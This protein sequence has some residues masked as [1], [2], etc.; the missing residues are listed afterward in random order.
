MARQRFISTQTTMIA[1][2]AGWLSAAPALAQQSDDEGGLQANVG[3]H[4]DLNDNIYDSSTQEIES[5]IARISP[6]LLLSSTP[7]KRQFSAQYVGDY[8]K[9][10][11]S[12]DDDYEDHSLT[13]RGLFRRGSRGVL[14][15]SAVFHQSA[16][17]EE[18]LL[19]DCYAPVGREGLIGCTGRLWS[20]SGHLIVSG[21]SCLFCR[22]NPE[23]GA[24]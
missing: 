15:V 8:G 19:C 13:G 11:D 5:W 10:F 16:A 17:Q 12:S 20:P 7:G 14:D 3:L 6:D 21:S 22:P 23:F 9:F 4:F 1:L 2:V 24:A 18:W